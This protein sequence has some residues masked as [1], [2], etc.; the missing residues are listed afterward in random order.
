MGVY[1]E[2]RWLEYRESV[3]RLH[4][5]RCAECG[6]SRETGAVLQVHHI[7]YRKGFSPW[8]YPVSDCIALCKGCHAAKHGKIIPLSGWYLVDEDD[9]ESLIGTCELCG[10]DIRYQY[11]VEHSSW[12]SMVVGTICCDKLTGNSQASEWQIQREKFVQA[13][14]RFIDSPRWKIPFDGVEVIEQEGVRIK[15]NRHNAG[16]RVSLEDCYVNKRIEG[17][18]YFNNAVDAK[19]LIFEFIKSENGR[20]IL[21]RKGFLSHIVKL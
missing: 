8:E 17:N 10:T 7:K 14:K 11:T 16:F 5:G 4:E 12:A 9:L 6:R 2:H 18:K 20:K 15:I 1:R 21:S 3:I 13:R 19:S